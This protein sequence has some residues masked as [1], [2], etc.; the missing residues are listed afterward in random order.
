MRILHLQS[1]QLAAW[2]RVGLAPVFP[3]GEAAYT[4]EHLARLRSL[5][6]MGGK[7]SSARSL[8]ARMEAMRQATGLENAL[9][10]TTAVR[11]G[12]GVAF[13]FGGALVDPMTRQL[14]FDFAVSEELRV[15]NA[16]PGGRGWT[17]PAPEGTGAE[18]QEM[19]L[20]GVQLEE[21][22]ATV[23][24]AVQVYESLL[25]LRPDHAPACINLGTIFYNQ[26][27]F[28]RAEAMYRRAA[29]ADPRYARLDPA[30]PWSAHARGQARK[31]LSVERLRIV[32]RRGFRVRATG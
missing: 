10:Q 28:D 1:R 25:Q 17:R 30:G 27:E 3:V 5:R 24:E 32:S 31:I 15:V 16:R 4:F 14:A 12:S 26:R 9:T 20:R 22:A 7:R 2:E 29:E 21:N 11:H 23:P 13:R 6:E 18:V 8:L 19:F